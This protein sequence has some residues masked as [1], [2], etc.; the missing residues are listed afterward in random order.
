MVYGV[1]K[2]L[3]DHNIIA[4]TYQTRTRALNSMLRQLQLMHLIS[5]CIEGDQVSCLICP[6]TQYQIRLGVYCV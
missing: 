1:E 3:L 2:K 5:V 6:Q 4:Y